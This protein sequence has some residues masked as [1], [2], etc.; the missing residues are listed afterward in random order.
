M[1]AR[2]PT[3]SSPMTRLERYF[4]RQGIPKVLQATMM[5]KHW[6]KGT[7]TCQR[8]CPKSRTAYYLYTG[9]KSI[10]SE[11]LF[12]DEFIPT[13]GVCAKKY[14]RIGL[15]EDPDADARAA[16][17]LKKQ[18][19]VITA[20]AKTNQVMNRSGQLIFGVQRMMKRVDPKPGF[21]ALFPNHKAGSERCHAKYNITEFS[22]KTVGPVQPTSMK[23]YYATNV[24]NFYQGS[25]WYVWQCYEEFRESQHAL[26]NDPK[27]FRHHPARKT[28]KECG[29]SMQQQMVGWVYTPVL[30]ATDTVPQ[31][32]RL[33]GYLESRRF[34]CYALERVLRASPIMKSLQQDYKNG[35]NMQL[36]GYDSPAGA[37]ESQEPT[38]A[39]FLRAYVDASRPFGHEWVVAALVMDIPLCP[40]HLTT[41]AVPPEWL[42][43][44][45]PFMWS[46]RGLDQ[47]FKSKVPEPDPG[48][49]LKEAR[50]MQPRSGRVVKEQYKAGIRENGMN[51]KRYIH[52][53]LELV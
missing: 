24:E 14:E 52:S 9:G 46:G 30:P 11:T 22:P 4:Q 7:L 15:P 8:G 25:K 29:L 34:Y 20:A 19:K 41:K 47:R 32:V 39:D 48:L 44:V 40:W 12:M 42:E 3:A 50:L 17:A 43:D 49:V 36:W 45:Q 26:F 18:G 37:L 2:S 23:P 6:Y 21:R 13:C 5:R 28:E 33:M 31:T 38:L 27:P 1:P 53:F 10:T 35:V 16:E 51:L